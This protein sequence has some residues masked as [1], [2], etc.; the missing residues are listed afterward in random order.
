M[1][2]SRNVVKHGKNSLAKFA[3]FVYFGLHT[4]KSW[5]GKWKAFAPGILY[6]YILKHFSIK[7]CNFTNFK[8]FFLT[9][10]TDFVLL[11]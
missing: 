7:V 2:W 1:F 6:F 8:M 3:N 9:V 10:L 5:T 11:A 4:K